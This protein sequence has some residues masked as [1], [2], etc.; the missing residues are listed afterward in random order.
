[1]LTCVLAVDG[2]RTSTK[3]GRAGL[4]CVCAALRDR[5]EKP[6]PREVYHVPP[7]KGRRCAPPLPCHKWRCHQ[8]RIASKRATRWLGRPERD[9]SCPSPGKSNISTSRPRRFKDTNR[10]CACSTG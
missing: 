5:A 10:R 9:N 6:A 1:L 8:S 4:I 3:P 2:A 7:G